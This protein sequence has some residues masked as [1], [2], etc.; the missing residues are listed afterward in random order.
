MSNICCRNVVV[1]YY[2]NL[3]HPSVDPPR[4]GL[5]STVPSNADQLLKD[6]VAKA[7]ANGGS[8]P[9]SVEPA[10]T[11]SAAN[12]PQTTVTVAS[13]LQA[14]KDTSSSGTSIHFDIRTLYGFDYRLFISLASTLVILL[15]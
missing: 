11:D 14:L 7:A 6:A 2:G 12:I 13:P 8:F 3:T 5:L 4:I 10:P 9:N 1:F 15:C